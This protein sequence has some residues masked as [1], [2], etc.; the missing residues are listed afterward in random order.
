M[1]ISDEELKSIRRYTEQ[2]STRDMII[3][4]LSDYNMVDLI[5]EICA[6]GKEIDAS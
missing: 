1:N 2:I 5:E 4:L 3:D 6:I